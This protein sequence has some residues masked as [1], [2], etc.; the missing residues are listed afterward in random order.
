MENNSQ[1]AL[2]FVDDEAAILAG[3]EHVFQDKGYTIDKALDSTQAME[4]LKTKKYAVVACDYSMPSGSGL[5]LIQK[6]RHL[7]PNASY[8][9][10][11]AKCDALQKVP[12]AQGD[13]FF[14]PKPYPGA[15]LFELMQRLV[16]DYHS[17]V[18]QL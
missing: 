8:L 1:D 14:V 9:I 12:S 4:H 3:Y 6:L 16:D 13:F 2:L 10:I 17:R 5:E 15:Q 11:S 18:A 7:Q